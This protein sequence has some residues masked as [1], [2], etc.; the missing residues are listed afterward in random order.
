MPGSQLGISFEVGLG[1]GRGCCLRH[2]L[3]LFSFLDST[4][5]SIVMKASVLPTKLPETGTS[6]LPHIACSSGTLR[7]L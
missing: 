1:G 5:T 3:G 2:A 7:W 6:K 4:A